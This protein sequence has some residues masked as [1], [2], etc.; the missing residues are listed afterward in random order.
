MGN[1][2]LWRRYCGSR[3]GRKLS[4][5]ID[6]GTGLSGCLWSRRYRCLS[7]RKWYQG[8]LLVGASGTAGIRHGRSGDWSG[9]GTILYHGK[10]CFRSIWR[11]GSSV[12]S[13]LLC[14]GWESFRICS[15]RLLVTRQGNLCNGGW[16]PQWWRIQWQQR[17]EFLSFQSFLWWTVLC[18]K[19]AVSCNRRAVLFGFGYFL[20]SQ[21]G[22]R[23][24]YF[25]IEIFLVHVLGWRPAGRHGA[26]CDEYQEQHLYQSSKKTSGLLDIQCKG[27]GRRFALEQ[28]M[29]QPALCNSS[30]IYCR[31]CLW[32]GLTAS[33][34]GHI[35]LWNILPGTDQLLLGW[36]S[37]SLE[38]WGWIRFELCTECTPSNGAWQL[39]KCIVN[40]EGQSAHFIR[41]FGRW[42]GWNRHLL[43]WPGTVYLFGGC[44]WL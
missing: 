17:L 39:E 3:R 20:H 44:L 13:W 7:S 19:L 23:I 31:C 5:W 28:Y 26:L 37:E 33:R 35:C 27:I 36:Q 14:A 25:G 18:S 29:G 22:K 24:G 38:L 16:R 10:K 15:G 1:V 11:N 8:S 41:R 30:W 34:Y 40:A 21:S 2:Y 32:Y 43:R 9:R 12:G 4:P 42:P 6:L